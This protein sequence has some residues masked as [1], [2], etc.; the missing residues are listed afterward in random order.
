[1]RIPGKTKYGGTATPDA[2]PHPNIVTVEDFPIVSVWSSSSARYY[3]RR[4]MIYGN[5]FFIKIQNPVRFVP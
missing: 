2:L 5:A 4:D 1:M 3:M